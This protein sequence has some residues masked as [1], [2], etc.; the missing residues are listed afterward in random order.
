MQRTRGA[1]GPIFW[2]RICQTSCEP[3]PAGV[4]TPSLGTQLPICRAY[5]LEPP[6]RDGPAG[7]QTKPDIAVL[8]AHA[9]LVITPRA[10]LLPVCNMG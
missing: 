3:L 5:V 1:H 9:M 7:W 4:L 2:A 8:V 10:W 6:P